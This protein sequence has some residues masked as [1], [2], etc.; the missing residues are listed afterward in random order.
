MKNLLSCYKNHINE[1]TEKS[2]QELLS[3]VQD[4]ILALQRTVD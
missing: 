4:S 2:Y 3:C 1:K